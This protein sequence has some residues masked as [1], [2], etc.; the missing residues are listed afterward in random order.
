MRRFGLTVVLTWAL[1][2]AALAQ[3]TPI[4]ITNSPPSGIVG[5]PYTYQIGITG[6]DGGPYTV[7]Y[8][9][10]TGMLPPGLT[11]SSSGLVQ[12][13][14]TQP[15]VFQFGVFITDMS[16][17]QGGGVLSFSIAAC[18][19][20]FATTSPLPA[21]EVDVPYRLTFN[22]TGCAAPYTFT[23]EATSP[24]NPNSLPSGL[25]LSSNGILSGTPDKAGVK[26][27]SV[28]VMEAHGG[29]SDGEFSLTINPAPSISTPSPL[30]DGAAGRPYSI[31]F[32][33][34]GG[35]PPYTFFVSSLPP[36][37]VVN[38]VG[39]LNVPSPQAG[40]Y[41]FGVG[42]RDSFNVSSPT[43][44][45]EVTF[46]SVDPSLQI[47]PTSLDFTATEGGNTPPSQAISISPA[48]GSS[49]FELPHTDGRRPTQCSCSV[50][51]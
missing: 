8:D 4:G 28:T 19:P 39:V 14:P 31:T 37:F 36:G 42:V 12:G 48:A 35:V 17:D 49:A 23:A 45:F 9:G 22:G 2:V 43:K 6:G 1:S 15:G 18:T 13:T 41:T 27:F 16:M 34:Q 7:Q 51:L 24:F 44:T 33:V 5:V 10:E 40:T 32:T 25:T 38:S 29:A 47:T 3:S 46:A 26:T 20:K 30:P 11:M 21:G 50:S